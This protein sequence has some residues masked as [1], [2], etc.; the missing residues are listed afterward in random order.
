MAIAHEHRIPH[1]VYAPMNGV[2]AARRHPPG[3][4]AIREAEIAKLPPGD[5]P[6]LTSGQRRNAPIRRGWCVFCPSTVH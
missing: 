3:D 6:V 5:D 2:Q 1:R 4:A